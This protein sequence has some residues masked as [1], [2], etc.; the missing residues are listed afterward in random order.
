[1]S[2]KNDKAGKGEA[3][4]ASSKSP[5]SASLKHGAKYADGKTTYLSGQKYP[6]SADVAAKLKASGHFHVVPAKGK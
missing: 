1:M 3:E 2:K 4:G 5:F 6:C